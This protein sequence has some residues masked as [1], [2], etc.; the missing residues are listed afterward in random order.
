VLT[1]ADAEGLGERT[2]VWILAAA[3]A[4]G[5]MSAVNGGRLMIRVGRKQKDL[6]PDLLAVLVVVVTV[7]VLL[8]IG[9]GC[10]GRGAVV[11]V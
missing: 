3:A 2:T 7:V 9:T 11:I 5:L 10:C 4:A 6:S 1:N 8:L